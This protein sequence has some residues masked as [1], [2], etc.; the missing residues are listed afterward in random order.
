MKK[1]LIFIINEESGQ[2]MVE[3]GLIL[4]MV[5]LVVIGTVEIL[6]SSVLNMYIKTENMMP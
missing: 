2:S 5:V 3:Y 1:L 6:G 4:I